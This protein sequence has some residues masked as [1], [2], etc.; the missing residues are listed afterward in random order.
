MAKIIIVG[1]AHGGRETVNGLLAANTDNEIHWYEH[2]Q[3]AT[4]LDWTPAD[5]EKERL[6]L[7]Q[8]VTLFDQTTVTKITPATHTITARNQ[9]GQLQTDHYDRLVL[10]IGS[11]PI[12]LP[13][14]G[15]ELSGVRSIQN[16]A[17]INDLKLAAKSAT[18]KNVVVIGG[19]YI[20][21][22]FAALFKQTGK[23]VT[24]IDVNARP[25]SHNLDSE[26]T[27]ILATASVENGL[28]LKMEERV[29]AILG[30][31]H[32]TAVQTDRGQYAADL[33]L[34]AVGNRPNT[35]WLRG[36]LALDTQ[37]L[38]ETDDYFQ[39]SIP[40]IYAIG[41]ATK[42]RFTPTGTKERVTLGSAAS[43]AGRLLA[44][45]LLNKQPI[46]FP[47][48]QATSALNVAGY[49]FA[50]TGLNTQLAVRMQQPVLATYIA[51]P[52]LVAAVPA[53]L[54][55][56]VHFKLFYD[57]AHRILGAQIMSTAE[58][59]SVINTVSLAIQM[60]ATLEQLAYGDFFFQPGLSQPV[61]VLSTASIQALQTL[62]T[63]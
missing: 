42:V 9:R 55:A 50:A 20:G 17:S 54:N 46:V 49:Y 44:H 52:R 63:K 31:T 28:R 40:D 19:G 24:V 7:S 37:G 59:T 36:T 43:H 12:Q 32:V 27:Q 6:A 34:V 48:V 11:L 26:F 62:A 33:V 2:G 15:A 22:N 16:R 10:S 14:P 35:A 57:K 3:F 47:G 8:Q 5:A 45:N 30:S 18:I 51:V 38:I 58:L 53:R 60:G 29:T 23:Q 4:A 56:T 61:D 41:D 25:F 1:A 13:I 39:T 21:M